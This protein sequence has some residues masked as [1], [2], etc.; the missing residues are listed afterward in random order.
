LG[1]DKVYLHIENRGNGLAK[2]IKFNFLNNLSDTQQYLVNRLNNEPIFI[3]GVSFLDTQ[4][5]IKNFLF[6]VD[7]ILS[8]DFDKE[9]LFNNLIGLNITYVDTA[10]NK[11]K[12][13]ALLNFSQL[14]S[15]KEDDQLKVIAENLK[16]IE[17]RLETSFRN[18]LDSL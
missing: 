4:Q 5:P 2:N 17:E 10:N 14:D 11:Y 3:Q 18:L 8:E 15:Y 6:K 13:E 16:S 12:S 7:D 9:K 1:V